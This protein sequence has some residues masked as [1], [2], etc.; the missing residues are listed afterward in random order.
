M[1]LTR[2]LS[3]VLFVVAIGLA[4]YLY[5]NINS[6]I[7]FKAE[8]TATETKITEKLAIIREAEKAYLERYGHYTANWDSLTNFIE[9]GRVP[10][11]VRKEIITP[12][13]YGEEKVEVKIDTV[14]FM[15]AR[16]RIF[17]KNFQ[18]NASTNGTFQGF[19]VSEG[20]YAVKGKAAYRLKEDGKPRSTTFPFTESGNITSLSRIKPGDQIRR[21]QN[22]ANLW[23]YHLNPNIDIATLRKVPG[24][25]SDKDFDIFVGKVKRGN[26]MVSVIE[27]RDPEP[28][29]PE[30][31]ASNEA[32]NRQPL[33]FG[34]RVDVS[35][36]GNWE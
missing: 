1:N 31:K 35:T 23:E 7:E 33:G 18:L 27:V 24:S 11:T 9:Q 34:S 25:K 5:S 21:G 6:T 13:S 17:K 3:I 30:R 8:V 36:G 2:I 16:D 14:G 22:L 12:L 29:N 20:E 4:W 19:L 26:S 32:K 10:I 28:L 15:S